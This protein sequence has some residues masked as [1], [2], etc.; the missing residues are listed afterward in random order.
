MRNDMEAVQE[1]G[2]LRII[3]KYQAWRS[4]YARSHARMSGQPRCWL[5][6]LSVVRPECVKR[7]VV[8]PP[9]L[10]QVKTDK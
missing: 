7:T 10:F 8:I 9:F 3:M 2:R 5:R 1:C 4:R 6:P